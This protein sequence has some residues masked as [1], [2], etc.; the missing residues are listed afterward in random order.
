MKPLIVLITV[1]FFASYT[2]PKTESV[3]SDP[4]PVHQGIHDYSDTRIP[5][6]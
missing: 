6:G 4:V 1:P 3:A 2:N 5:I